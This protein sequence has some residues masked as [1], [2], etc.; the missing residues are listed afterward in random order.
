LVKD[1]KLAEV[2]R[3]PPKKAPKYA[4]NLEMVNPSSLTASDETYL[5][6]K[7]LAWGLRYK[8]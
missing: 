5:E 6:K 2:D 4:K 8:K 1:I 3:L 7:A